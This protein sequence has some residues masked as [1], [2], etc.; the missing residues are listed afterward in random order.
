MINESSVFLTARILRMGKVLFSQ[1]QGFLPWS[2]SRSFLF[3]GG[4]GEGGTPVPSSF[5]G[6]CSQVLCQ[7]VPQSHLVGG[8]PRTGPPVRTGVPPPPHQDKTRESTCYASCGMFLA[9]TQED[10]LVNLE[11]MKHRIISQIT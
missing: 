8:S 10:F 1:S 9:V 6:L 11:S 5:P 3:G 2:S 4:G 7:G